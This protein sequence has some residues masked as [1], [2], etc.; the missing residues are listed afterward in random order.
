MGAD[1]IRSSLLRQVE[2]SSDEFIR[3]VSVVVQAMVQQ[4]DEASTETVPPPWAKPKTVTE[5]NRELLLAD[6]QI[7][8]GEYIT[9]ADLRKKYKRD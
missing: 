2:S 6:E 4:L 1:Q 7:D 8:R 5:R 3:L 9:L